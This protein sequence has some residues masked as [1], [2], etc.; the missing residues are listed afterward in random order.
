M[1]SRIVLD[2][3]ELVSSY[4]STNQTNQTTR[5]KASQL[6]NELRSYLLLLIKRLYMTRHK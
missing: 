2:V 6:R 5:S 1:V 4:E 3:N